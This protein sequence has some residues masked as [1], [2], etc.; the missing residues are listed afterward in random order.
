MNTI[1]DPGTRCPEMYRVLPGGWQQCRRGE[2]DPAERHHAD[3]VTWITSAPTPVLR[4][5]TCTDPACCT[6]PARHVPYF[7]ASAAPAKPKARRS[8]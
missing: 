2:H 5:E 4:Y 7:G 8:R 1:P 3:G 6:W